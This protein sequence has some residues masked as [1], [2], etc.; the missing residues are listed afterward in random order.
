MATPATV[1]ID[2]SNED[3]GESVTEDISNIVYGV[4]DDPNLTLG[5][6]NITA[7]DNSYEKILRLH[8]SDLGD[9]NEVSEIRV[10]RVGDLGHAS[11]SHKTNARESSYGGDPGYD[12]PET[13]ASGEATQDMPAE[14]PAGANVGIG[15]SLTGSLTA[16]GRSDY[17][18]SQIQTDAADSGQSAFKMI[19]MYKV[20]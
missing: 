7:G 5:S 8:V 17:W 14:A 4:T 20:E 3:S 9:D 12:T 6:S 10:W 11:T 13:G 15:G 16:V 1:H 18:F 19:V 2:E